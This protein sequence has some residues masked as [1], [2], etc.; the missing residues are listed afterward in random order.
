MKGNSGK[1][2]KTKLGHRTASEGETCE[3]TRPENHMGRNVLKQCSSC[4]Q[5]TS[6]LPGERASQL[7][8]EKWLKV[9]VYLA[10]T[11]SL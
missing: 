6:R 7:E 1:K 10:S 9:Y 4:N 5:V 8:K 3:T 2:N 11:L